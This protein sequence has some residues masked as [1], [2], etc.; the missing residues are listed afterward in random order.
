MDTGAVNR[1]DHRAENAITIRG[2]LSPLPSLQRLPEQHELEHC[3]ALVPWILAQR[4]GAMVVNGGSLLRRSHR[5]GDPYSSPVSL[6]SLNI[7]GDP[8]YGEE[9]LLFGV[10]QH[11]KICI[12]RGKRELSEV[13]H[14][15]HG[16]VHLRLLFLV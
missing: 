11:F 5:P 9:R 14:P 6:I 4:A 15:I 2:R 16:P 12:T 8:I 1:I 10:T 13:H 3:Q 7:A